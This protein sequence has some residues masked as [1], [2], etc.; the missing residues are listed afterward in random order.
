MFDPMFV[1]PR[2]SEALYRFVYAFLPQVA[3]VIGPLRSVQI[4][5]EDLARLEALRAERAI[6]APNHPTESDPVVMLFLSRRLRYRFNFLSTRENLDGLSGWVLNHLGAYSVIRG[7]PD[8]ESLRMTRKLLAEQD[9]KVVIF[10]EGLTYQH[11]ER[12]MQFQGGVAQ[13]GFWAL[14]DLQKAGKT[15][16]L[17]LVPIALK[18]VCS[19]PHAPVIE[20]ALGE[21]EHTLK[22][23]PTPKATWY[24]RLQRL[25]ERVVASIE[26]AERLKPA[27]GATLT[28]RIE[29]VRRAT[30]TRI[31]RAIDVEVDLTGPRSDQIFRVFNELKSWVGALSADHNDY[32]ERL[33]HRKLEVAAPLF[34]DLFRLYEVI[35]V[36]GDYVAAEPTAERFLEVLGRLQREVYGK[37]R[38]D[39]PREAHVRVVPP[40]R[41]EEKLEEYRKSK[42]QVVAGVTQ[43]LAESI[44]AE[45]QSMIGLSTPLSLR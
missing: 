39:C 27:E 15:P 25:G 32:E 12:L 10:P 33:Y 9:R 43:T 29:A 4:P 17:P 22:L 16:S 30:L 34:A 26:A 8:R 20:R 41:L 11:N 3:R 7:F 23:P 44:Q 38:H 28:D 31:A 5:P 19:A 40:I 35:A 36:T 37:V 42:R 45:L 14:E 6:I 13:M 21:L 18:Y 1:P 24:E 2:N